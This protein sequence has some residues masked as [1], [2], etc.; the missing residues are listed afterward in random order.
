MAIIIISD[1]YLNF[2]KCD[3]TMCGWFSLLGYIS[4]EN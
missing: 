1:N 3:K 4:H 2:L